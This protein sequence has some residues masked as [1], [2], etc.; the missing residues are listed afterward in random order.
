MLAVVSTASAQPWG[1]LRFSR[2][3]AY[4]SQE[5]G[6]LGDLVPTWGHQSASSQPQQLGGG[7]IRE[8]ESGLVLEK[9]PFEGL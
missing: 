4:R 2:P 3:Q 1:G 9:V 7:A 6:D 5:Q 8:G